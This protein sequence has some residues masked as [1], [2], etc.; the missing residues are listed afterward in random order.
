MLKVGN[1]LL[2]QIHTHTQ[3]KSNVLCILPKIYCNKVNTRYKLKNDFICPCEEIAA[4]VCKRSANLRDILL[5]VARKVLAL[6]QRTDFVCVRWTHSMHALEGC[7]LQ[8]V[9][10][11]NCVEIGASQQLRLCDCHY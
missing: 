11:S 10:S 6:A 7:Q 3:P 1:F 8:L 2:N 9:C 5:E 4:Y